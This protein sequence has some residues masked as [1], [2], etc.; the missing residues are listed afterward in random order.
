[1][2]DTSPPS[3]DQ[4]NQF[5]AELG[6]CLYLYQQIEYSLKIVLP[7][8]APAA[9]ATEGAKDE[10][11]NWNDLLDSKTTLGQLVKLLRE[12]IESD[13]KVLLEESWRQLVEHRNELVHLVLAQPF[14][15]L[16]NQQ[17]VAEAMQFLK[18]RLQFAVA[19]L[20]IVKQFMAVL[21]DIL[22]DSITDESPSH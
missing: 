14:G 19:M 22:D 16:R 8:M 10:L 1:M 15:H 5:F 2:T 6:R 21:I 13:N 17:E 18:G 12:R 9:I 11:L 20:E 3:H 7:H 4:L